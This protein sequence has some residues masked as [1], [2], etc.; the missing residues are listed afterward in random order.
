MFEILSMVLR[1]VFI[2]IIYLFILNIIRLIYLDIRTTSESAK[3]SNVA[4]LKVANQ[5][6]KLDFKIDEYTP[7]VGELIIGRGMRTDLQINDRVVSK[8]HARIF[9]EDGYYYLDDTDSANGTFLNGER[10]G[11]DAIEI[12][13]GDMISIGKVQFIF[14]DRQEDDVK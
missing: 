13:D 12:V 3:K 2:I 14:V 5:M 7:V 10:I 11:E 6:N 8:T 4:Y 1:Y 9:L